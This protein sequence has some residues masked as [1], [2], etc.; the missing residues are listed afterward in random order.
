MQ[1]ETVA[2]D[3]P[4][5]GPAAPGR[6]ERAD[7][8]RQ[9]ESSPPGS[10]KVAIWA[11]LTALAASVSAAGGEQRAH[12]RPAERSGDEAVSA[13][14]RSPGAGCSAAHS[15]ERKRA[16]FLRLP[17]VLRAAEFPA[18]A[19][20]EAAPTPA[21]TLAWPVVPVP[22]Q[23]ARFLDSRCRGPRSSAPLAPDL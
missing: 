22:R 21:L 10:A 23:A 15:L 16:E 3:W 6:L 9:A 7:P 5:P 12:H 11:L 8:A 2:E 18:R 13:A 20:P 4:L 14:A 19:S 1:R 17:G